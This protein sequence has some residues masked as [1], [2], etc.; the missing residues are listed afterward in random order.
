MSV[1]LAPIVVADDDAVGREL[2]SRVLERAGHTTVT[3]PDGE[4]AWE[5]IQSVKPPLAVLDWDMP[6]LTG[7]DVLRRVKLTVD[8]TPPY[9]LLLT[10]RTEVRDRV[11]GLT[12]GADDYLTKPFEPAELVAR[13]EVGLRVVQLQRSLSTRVT[14]LE[15]AL[16]HV[17]RLERLLPICAQCK[18]IQSDDDWHDLEGFLASNAGVRFSHGACPVC[19]ERWLQAEGLKAPGA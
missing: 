4:K 1:F 5:L 8:R 18:R 17:N 7:L 16:A 15:E 11:R 2:V 9:V 13:V 3:A 19:A 14:E 12:V 6:H 10:S